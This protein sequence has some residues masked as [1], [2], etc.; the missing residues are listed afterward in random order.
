[1][2][3]TE[4]KKRSKHLY[5]YPGEEVAGNLLSGCEWQQCAAARAFPEVVKYPL[6]GRFTPYSL[7]GTDVHLNGQIFQTKNL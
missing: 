1:M 4:L 5:D 6:H 3:E 7:Q 2:N